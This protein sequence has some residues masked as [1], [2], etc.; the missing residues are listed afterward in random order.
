MTVLPGSALALTIDNVREHTLGARIPINIDNLTGFIAGNLPAHASTH[1]NGGSDQITVESLHTADTNPGRILTSNGDGTTSFTVVG[2]SSPLNYTAAPDY[3]LYGNYTAGVVG[4]LSMQIG[5]TASA[6]G[7][8]SIAFG[9]GANVTYDWGVAIGAGATITD[10]Y[11]VAVGYAT[12]AKT[13]V[14][15]GR[16]SSAQSDNIAIGYYA[17][18][19]T[20]YNNAIGIGNYSAVGSINGVALGANATIGAYSAHGV[21][22]GSQATV[23]TS[24]SYGVALGRNAQ[25]QSKGVVALGAW[26]GYGASGTKIVVVGYSATASTGVGGVAVGYRAGAPAGAVA[27]GYSAEATLNSVAIGN[28]AD[29]TGAYGTRIAIGPGIVN[30]TSGSIKIGLANT[31]GNYIQMGDFT[32]AAGIYAGTHYI[33]VTLNGATYR[34]LL[35]AV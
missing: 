17:S 2:G 12:T 29:C 5:N 21:A 19:N 14:A 35:N 4:K 10:S 27:V 33:L 34:I 8:Y 31:A 24:A 11:G 22:I 20:L 18:A 7:Y 3:G 9:Y 26:A 6:P 28:N 32:P 1:E 30:T 23:S 13:G 25:A 15:I 16:G